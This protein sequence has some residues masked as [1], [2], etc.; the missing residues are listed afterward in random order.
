MTWCGRWSDLWSYESWCK[1]TSFSCLRIFLLSAAEI[2]ALWM[3]KACRHISTRHLATVS[4]HLAMTVGGWAD[5][6]CN[7]R[8][9]KCQ[10]GWSLIG[11]WNKHTM[12]MKR[13]YYLQWP[14]T[15]HWDSAAQVLSRLSG[16]CKRFLLFFFSLSIFFSYDTNCQSSR[17]HLYWRWIPQQACE[18]PAGLHSIQPSRN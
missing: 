4:P 11:R 13:R 10:P 16:L 15:C 5:S 2:A 3:W 8:Q 14:H 18:P 12:K 6:C 7:K 17:G 1:A 9:I